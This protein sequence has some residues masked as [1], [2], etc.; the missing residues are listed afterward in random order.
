MQYKGK[1]YGNVGGKM[2]FDTGK[3]SED[4]DKLENAVESLRSRAIAEL[5]GM[6]KEAKEQA[7]HF[8]EIRME[9]SELCSRA[10]AQAYENSIQRIENLK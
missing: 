1:L 10:M 9:T 7:D 6:K 4:W 2:Y 3:T 5:E 8:Q